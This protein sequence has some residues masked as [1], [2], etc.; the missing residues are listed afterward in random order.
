MKGF[1]I[2]DMSAPALQGTHICV[3]R[4]NREADINM[5]AEYKSHFQLMAFRGFTPFIDNHNQF[6][7]KC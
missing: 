4:P 1:G 3:G 6:T 2:N 5:K 7:F